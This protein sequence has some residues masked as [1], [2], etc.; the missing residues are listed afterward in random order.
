MSPPSPHWGSEHFE[1]KRHVHVHFL[2]YPS[3][4]ALC[5]VQSKCSILFTG[6]GRQGGNAALDFTMLATPKAQCAQASAQAVG[7][8]STQEFTLLPW[9]PV[10]KQEA[11]QAPSLEA[12]MKQ[13]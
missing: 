4:P 5:M 6:G 2:I 9:A 3:F 10:K 13:T 11:C 8:A 7:G 12:D 1:A